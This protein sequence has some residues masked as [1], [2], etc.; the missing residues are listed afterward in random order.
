MLPCLYFRKRDLRDFPRRHLVGFGFS[1]VRLSLESGKASVPAAAEMSRCIPGTKACRPCFRSLRIFRPD[2]YGCFCLSPCRPCY[3]SASGAICP[4][5]SCPGWLTGRRN[6]QALFEHVDF[7]G[8]EVL[9][10]RNVVQRRDVC[11]ETHL[12]V[13]IGRV[14]EREALDRTDHHVGRKDR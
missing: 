5:P 1:A 14:V 3:G 2:R 13:V 11:V 8:I 4:V 6:A 12:D 7:F 9:D 10:D